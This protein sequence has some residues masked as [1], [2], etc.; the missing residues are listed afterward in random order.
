MNAKD[1]VL[2]A[3]S[4]HQPD[5]I[6]RVDFFWEYPEPW[7]ARLGPVEQVNDVTILVP[8]E[9]TFPTAARPLKNQ[10][11][12]Q[13]EIDRWGRVIRRQEGAYFSETIE[14]PFKDRQAVDSLP[15]DPPDLELRYLQVETESIMD[16]PL[17]QDEASPSQVAEAVEH[18]RQSGC[19]FGKTGGPYL[20]STYL[21]G[22]I[23]F[24]MDLASDQGLARA[25]VERVTDHLTAIGLEE[26]RRW[27]L[28]ETG[29]WIFDD[30]A[31]NTGPMFSPAVFEAIFLPAYK[32]MVAAFKAAG[33]RYVFFHSDGDIR[34]FLDLL[35]AAGIDGI[36]PI[37]PRANMRLPELRKQYPKL[38]L[39]GGMDNT[40]TLE[41]GPLDKIRRE[42]RQIIEVAQDGG[43]II[44][45]GSIG[46]EISL[47]NF[48]AYVETCSTDGN[49]ERRIKSPEIARIEKKQLWSPFDM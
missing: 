45:S 35:I 19:L 47:E 11:G 7:Q 49:F 34:R 32:R 8:N 43:A 17:V 14:V 29:V 38:I 42:A 27:R 44:G 3:C 5:R 28:Q 24:L 31:Y 26:I 30:M 13:T 21:R 22:E 16:H 2:A 18:V 23:Q 10:D 9:G 25:I 39:T 33:A 1:R 46:P 48:C 36:N 41:K 6:P 12:Y 37:E 4:F 40:G 15:F 20:R